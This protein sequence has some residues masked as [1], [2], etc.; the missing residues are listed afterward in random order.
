[1]TAYNV[2]TNFGSKDDL[3]SG[4]TAKKIKGSEFT[5]EFNNIATGVNS[6][7][8]TTTVNTTTATANAA[9]PKAG[10]TMSGAIAMGTSKIT[11]AGN[12]TDAQD[13]ATKA[14]V[15]TSSGAALPK[16]GGTVTGNVILNDN[17]KALFGTGS[18]LEIYHSGTH[19]FIDHTASAGSLYLRSAQNLLIQNN[20]EDAIICTEDGAVT[21]YH[22]SVAKAAT[23]ATGVTVT[24][25]VSL[26][27]LLRVA[28][29]A[30]PSSGSTAGD[31][32]YDSTSNKLRCYNGSGWN[33]LF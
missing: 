10:G 33:D 32:Y 20:A 17:V 12:P 21:L 31:V 5:T 6:K 25:A 30:E 29:S 16:A 13:V 28:P 1:M 11:G 23:S 26:S 7:A 3:A 22:N 15:D 9:L 18:D 19:S 27:T 24:G 4:N 14:Y 8:D 2:T